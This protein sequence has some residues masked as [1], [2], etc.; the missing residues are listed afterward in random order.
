M[1]P[2]SVSAVS[3][4]AHADHRPNPLLMVGA[5]GVVF[6]DIGTSPIYAFRGSL[7]AAG[8]ASQEMIVLGVLSL[9]FWALI[10]V[11]DWQMRTASP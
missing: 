1:M 4:Q 7:K 9:L 6:G 5:L 8:G 10:L 3:T 2:T 11:V